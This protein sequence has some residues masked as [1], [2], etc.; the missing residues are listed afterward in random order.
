MNSVIISKD[1]KM[2][3][4]KLMKLVGDG[5]IVLFNSPRHGVVM[6]PDNN[7]D[8]KIGDFSANWHT[9]NLWTDF[10]GKIELSND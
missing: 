4:P 8:H 9:E 2:P 5:L 6:V 7:G 10:D 1:C 3:Y